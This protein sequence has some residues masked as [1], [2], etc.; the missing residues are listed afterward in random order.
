MARR[1]Y[2]LPQMYALR[3]HPLSTEQIH[4]LF[5]HRPSADLDWYNS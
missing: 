2:Y 1:R 3:N 4:A 5:D